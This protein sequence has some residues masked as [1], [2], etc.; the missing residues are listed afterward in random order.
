MKKLFC[1]IGMMLLTAAGCST[2]KTG[3]PAVTGASFQTYI[4]EAFPSDQSVKS[5]GETASGF[6]ESTAEESSK[7]VDPPL[8]LHFTDYKAE[9]S[10]LA[11]LLDKD[12]EVIENFLFEHSEYSMNGLCGREDIEF[13]MQTLDEP[14]YPVHDS[15]EPD[16]ITLLRFGDSSEN[17]QIW[18]RYEID[19]VVYGFT[20]TKFRIGE[21]I[22]NN[23][24]NTTDLE[25]VSA[26]EDVDIYADAFE[27]GKESKVMTFHLG[28]KGK[29]I[30]ARVY[31]AKDLQAA[32]EGLQA[33]G[34]SSL[35]IE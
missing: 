22:T 9:V 18:L 1:F 30:N 14:V 20:I 23:K 26:L 25:H 35:K 21:I 24:S 8:Q 19:G 6:D 12:D 11:G 17:M 15:A 33:F 31:D 4:S 32:L 2:Q 29:Y 7:P 10:A 3:D 28:L 27:N 16:E 13:L 5:S 34:F